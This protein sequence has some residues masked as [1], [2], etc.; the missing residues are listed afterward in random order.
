MILLARIALILL[1][2]GIMY[3]EGQHQSKP[4]VGWI[5]GVAL[6]MFAILP[7][8]PTDTHQS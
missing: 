1:A 3:L 8:K 4:G 7:Y 6:L 2:I 5:F